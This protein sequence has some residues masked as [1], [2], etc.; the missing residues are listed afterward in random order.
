MLNYVDA[1]FFI[2]HIKVSTVHLE[3]THLPLAVHAAALLSQTMKAECWSWC[4]WIFLRLY[5]HPEAAKLRQISLG[6]RNMCTLVDYFSTFFWLF[7]NQPVSVLP[8][9]GWG[10]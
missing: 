4:G 3:S 1:D 10:W 6:N 2:E 9:R 8:Q 7:L 5:F